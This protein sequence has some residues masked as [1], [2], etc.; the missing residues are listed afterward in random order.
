MSSRV[1]IDDYDHDLMMGLGTIYRMEGLACI[2]ID[3]ALH[4]VLA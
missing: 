1:W 2:H 3:S 4:A